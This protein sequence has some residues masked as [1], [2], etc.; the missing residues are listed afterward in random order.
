MI[1]NRKILVSLREVVID[2]S[3]VMSFLL[4]KNFRKKVGHSHVWFNSFAKDRKQPDVLPTILL[5]LK[6]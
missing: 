4:L 2:G 3:S 5:D 6:L 1:K